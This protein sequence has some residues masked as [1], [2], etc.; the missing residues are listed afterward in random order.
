MIVSIPD[1]DS[2]LREVIVASD[3]S[4]FSMFQ[5]PMG[6]VSSAKY[7]ITWIAKST[8][9]TFQSPMGIVSS[10][11]LIAYASLAGAGQVSIPDGDSFLR[12]VL[13]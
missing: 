11:K 3:L 7:G 2:F 13:I 9:P 10:A 1:G 6:I 4:M 5:S 12:E 8:L